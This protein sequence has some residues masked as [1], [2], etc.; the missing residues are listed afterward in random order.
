MITLQK[1]EEMVRKDKLIPEF[2]TSH[3]GMDIYVALSPE[4]RDPDDF[5]DKRYYKAI[6][7]VGQH[8]SMDIASVVAIDV[9]HDLNME[10]S[11][12]KQSRINAAVKDA[13]DYI[14]ASIKEG[15]HGNH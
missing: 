4:A 12:R 15:V 1:W 14:E 7:A 13:K 3:R 2:Q 9:N 6:W 8:G 5:H 10:L 11:A